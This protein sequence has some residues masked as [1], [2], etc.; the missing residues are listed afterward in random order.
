MF[1]PHVEQPPVHPHTCTAHYKALR[2]VLEGGGG[3]EGVKVCCG[4]MKAALC[5]VRPSAMREVTLEVPKV[6]TGDD[7]DYNYY[8]M[9]EESSQMFDLTVP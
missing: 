7:H 6:C 9:I 1:T 2:R 8:S 4:D 5:E 3:W